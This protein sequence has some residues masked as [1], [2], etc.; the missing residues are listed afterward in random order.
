[1][2]QLVEVVLEE[3]SAIRSEKFKRSTPEKGQFGNQR[4][5]YV[6]RKQPEHKEV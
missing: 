5:R 6:L 1:M 4:N 3:E 2:A